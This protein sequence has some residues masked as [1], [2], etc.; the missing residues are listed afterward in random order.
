MDRRRPAWHI[1]PQVLLKE[2]F[3][4]GFF[5]SLKVTPHFFYKKKFQTLNSS[6]FDQLEG[7][8]LKV[9]I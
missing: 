8:N 4:R 1:V 2:R 5:L 7:V 6:L 9:K 3:P